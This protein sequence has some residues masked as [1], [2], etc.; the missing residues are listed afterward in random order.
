M[1][2]QQLNLKISYSTFNKFINNLLEKEIIKKRKVTDSNQI[3]PSTFISLTTK[4]KN[5][6]NL[7]ILEIQITTNKNRILY[8]LL[9]FFQCYKRSNLLSERQFKYFLKKIGLKFENMEQMDKKEL[10]QIN[11]HKFFSNVTNSYK[12]YNNISIGEFRDSSKYYYVVLP[13]FTIEECFDYF[14]LLQKCAEPRPF[15]EY[16][17]CLEIPYIHFHNF[18]KKEISDAVQLLKK[19]GIIKPIADIYPGEMRYDICNDS[20]KEILNDY[21]FLHIFDFHISF[22]RLVYNKKPSD[23]DKEYMKL[24]FGEQKLKHKL[25][26][27]YDLRKKN[28]E[29]FEKEIQEKYGNIE[30]L[31]VSRNKIVENIEKYTGLLTENDIYIISLVRDLFNFK[32]Y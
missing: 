25:A 28:K 24:Y 11:H 32:Y 20:V 22:Q 6:Y 8:Q 18:S 10:E 17:K 30:E 21:W 23:A 4:G 14:K 5:D 19:Y 9:L 29:E 13:G 7:R 1:L 27:I 12:T 31:K 15:S 16:S 26:L 3:I 2:I